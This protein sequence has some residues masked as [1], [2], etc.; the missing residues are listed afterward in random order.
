M[1]INEHEM[2]A[3]EPKKN[4]GEYDP[5][6]KKQYELTDLREFRQKA[7]EIKRLNDAIFSTLGCYVPLDAPKPDPFLPPTDRS[8]DE[9]SFIQVAKE[10]N[11]QNFD[12]MN[13]NQTFQSSRKFIFHFIFHS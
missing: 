13:S 2:N 11:P 9:A 12:R 8:W 3:V 4:K 10:G 5:N 1:E 6:S 7:R